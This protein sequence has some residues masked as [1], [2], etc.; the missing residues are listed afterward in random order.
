MRLWLLLAALCVQTG[1]TTLEGN[2][3]DVYDPLENTNRKLFGVID[4]VDRKVI[5]PVARGYQAV[6]PNWAERGVSNFFRNVRRVDSIANSL[7]QGKAGHAGEDL[8]GLLVNTTV[9][10]GGLFDVGA[11]MG[12]RHHDEDFGQTLA[13]WGVTRTRY[14][15]LPAG[16]ST[17]RDAPG[18]LFKSWVPSAILS[19]GYTF[20]V[21]VLDLLSVRADALPLSDA[22]DQAA[23]DPYVFTRDAWYQRRKFVSFDGDPPIDDLFDEFDSE[24]QEEMQDE[25]QEEIPE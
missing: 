12:L 14:I 22:R 8:A 9:G 15:Y 10:I 20:W 21:S 6:M 19:G 18:T 3:W 13:V 4:T 5:S 7:L 1:C 24:F 17:I 16:P 25:V 11:R 23:L 2:Q